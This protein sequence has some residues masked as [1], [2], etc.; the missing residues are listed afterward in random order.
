MK[1]VIGKSREEIGEVLKSTPRQE[2]LDI[3]C[4]LATPEPHYSPRE[5]AQRRG[6]KKETILRLI[7]EGVIAP[8]HA[9][10]GKDYRIPLSAIRDWDKR[11]AIHAS[12]RP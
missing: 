9:P 4:A 7:R 12:A 8:V 3:I 6:L 2:L 5:I 1:K 10:T 11:T